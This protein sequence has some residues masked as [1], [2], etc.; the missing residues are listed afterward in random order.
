MRSENIDT[1]PEMKTFCAIVPT[2]GLAP[3][4]DRAG[5]QA[6]AT[7]LD[8]PKA[9]TVMTIVIGEVAYQR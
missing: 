5:A 4:A 1:E 3:P 9:E 2:H 7:T 8:I 6:L